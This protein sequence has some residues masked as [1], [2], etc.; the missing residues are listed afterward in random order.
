M[1]WWIIRLK[2]IYNR[3]NL[4]VVFVSPT[5]QNVNVTPNP[6][7]KSENVAGLRNKINKSWTKWET[8]PAGRPCMGFTSSPNTNWKTKF[9]KKKKSLVDLSTDEKTYLDY[10]RNNLRHY[11]MSNNT[12]A[13]LKTKL[14]NAKIKIFFFQ[15]KTFCKTLL[16]VMHQEKCGQ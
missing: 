9:Q 8:N 11:S 16:L 2:D 14:K 12:Y 7:K 15:A 5:L 6:E 1:F 10:N 4:K 3:S 13:T